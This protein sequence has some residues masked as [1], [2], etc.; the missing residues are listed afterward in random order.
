MSDLSSLLAPI[1]KRVEAYRDHGTPG[2]HAP[3]DR[4]QLL[5]ALDAVLALH[6]PVTYWMTDEDADISY[7]TKQDALEERTDL[8]EADLVPFE[9]CSHCKT[10]EEAPCEGQCVREV[11]YRESLWPCPTVTAVTAALGEQA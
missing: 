9:L 1:R 11:G 7:Q 8:T 2:L 10:I 5:A 3:Q 6:K 4:A